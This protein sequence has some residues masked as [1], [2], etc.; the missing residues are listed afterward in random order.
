MFMSS[1]KFDSDQQRSLSLSQLWPSTLW[2]LLQVEALD[3]IINNQHLKK[4]TSLAALSVEW[5][6]VCVSIA[7]LHRFRPFL[8]PATLLAQ[9]VIL[10]PYL[11]FPLRVSRKLLTKKGSRSRS[12][13][14]LT[15]FTKAVHEARLSTRARGLS[16]YSKKC[17][18]VLTFLASLLVTFLGWWFVTLFNG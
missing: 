5:L 2:Q 13:G 4:T 8:I 3:P 11:A 16:A 12:N 14:Q 10:F 17:G 1:S 7:S 6:S 18:K 15:E 9:S